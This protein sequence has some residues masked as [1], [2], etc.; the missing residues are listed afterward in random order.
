L[1]CLGN[2][3]P[4]HFLDP[5]YSRG[6]D[7]VAGAVWVSYLPLQ[8]V[9][10]GIFPVPFDLLGFLSLLLVESHFFPQDGLKSHLR[11]ARVPSPTELVLEPELAKELRV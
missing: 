10:F 1:V 5:H 7:V 8:L 11:F 4:F 6:V 9:A 2:G 3:V